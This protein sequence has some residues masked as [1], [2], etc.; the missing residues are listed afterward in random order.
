M[1][2]IFRI[3]SYVVQRGGT[4]GRRRYNYARTATVCGP[5]DLGMQ[6][7]GGGII[8][9]C[10]VLIAGRFCSDSSGVM[11]GFKMALSSC[12]TKGA[13]KSIGTGVCITRLGISCG[14]CSFWRV[15]GILC[16]DTIFRTVSCVW[17]EPI[18][19]GSESSEMEFV[20]WTAY[21]RFIANPHLSWSFSPAP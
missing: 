18:D 21:I 9:M 13:G 2:S 16:R 12:A 6:R 7:K 14:L 15:W 3:K 8:R 20:I 4:R 5:T 17:T 11:I 10:T 19:F 1:T